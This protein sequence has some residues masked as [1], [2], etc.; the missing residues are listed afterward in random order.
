M[1]N[2][3]PFH[4]FA[5]RTKPIFN[6]LVHVRII[7]VPIYCFESFCV[8]AMGDVKAE[9]TINSFQE[10]ETLSSTPEIWK[11][12]AGWRAIVIAM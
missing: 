5:Y 1:Q 9:P 11:V 12:E 8:L 4:P 2:R 10:V 3:R 6:F 7:S